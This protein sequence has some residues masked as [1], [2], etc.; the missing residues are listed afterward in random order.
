MITIKKSSFQPMVLFIGTFIIQFFFCL[1]VLLAEKQIVNPYY[2]VETVSQSDGSLFDKTIIN[3]PPAPPDGSSRPAVALPL[4]LPSA[5]NAVPDVPYY[6]WCFGCSATSAAMIAAYYDRNGYRNMYTGPANGGVMPLNNDDYWSTWVD[7]AGDTRH[8]CPLSATQLGL[9]GRST[10]GHVD[11]FWV[12]YDSAVVDPFITNGWAQ[13]PLGGCTADYMGTNQSSSPMNNRDGATTFWYNSNGAKTTAEAIFAA[14]AAYYNS[15]GMYGIKEFYESRGYA[16]VE[17]FNQY[18]LGYDGNTLGFTYAQYKA[19][20][21]AGRP[22]M[23]HVEGHTMVGFGYNDMSN[24][25]YLFDTWD[26]EGHFMEWGG[27]YGTNP[28]MAHVGV[29][30][31]KLGPAPAP[32]VIT[33]PSTLLLY[34]E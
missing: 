1:P 26:H 19:E 27:T 8:R 2:S 7:G 30:I 18:I 34:N 25:I 28:P 6:T 33:A 17:A 12:S 14:G 13:H 4:D 23:I 11:D 9:D 31:V 22:V 29:T 20:I 16:V 5:A 3:G 10:R 15:S 32:P 21:D 24:W